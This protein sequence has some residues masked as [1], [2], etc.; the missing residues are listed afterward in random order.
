M[1]TF[2][3][4][5]YDRDKKEI[6]EL[7][8][9]LEID[10]DAYFEHVLTEGIFKDGFKKVGD[11]WKKNV[12]AGNV[13]RLQSSYDQAKKSV[14]NFITN[15]MSLKKNKNLRDVPLVDLYKA[16][17]HVKQ[18]LDGIQQQVASVDQHA[19]GS[20]AN[21]PYADIQNWNGDTG[22]GVGQQV[23]KAGQSIA[24]YRQN[25]ATRKAANQRAANPF[26]GPLDAWQAQEK[27]P[28]RGWTQSMRDRA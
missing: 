21:T 19:R 1:Q 17:K 27:S 15:L 25:R 16:V 12:T 11:W 23:A 2:N 26:S 5:K 22:L 14:D 8:C 7:I 6:A 3:E 24:D 28:Q 10:P 20:V 13:V 9:S 4:Y 18:S